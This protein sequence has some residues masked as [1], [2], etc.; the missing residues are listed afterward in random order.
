MVKV[1]MFSSPSGL[2][3]SYSKSEKVVETKE[4]AGFRP[5]RGFHILIQ[6]IDYIVENRAEMFSS[7]SGLS[8][9]YSIFQK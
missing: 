8:Y 7:P 4:Q 5:L 3:Y 9:S 1:R 2:S 6:D